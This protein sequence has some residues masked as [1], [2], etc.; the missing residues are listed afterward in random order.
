MNFGKQT[1]SWE[2][3]FVQRGVAEEEQRWWQIRVAALEAVFQFMPLAPN[4]LAVESAC[5]DCERGAHFCLTQP[6]TGWLEAVT[7]FGGPG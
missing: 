6:S 5:S 4:A 1:H 2:A 3:A 7:W